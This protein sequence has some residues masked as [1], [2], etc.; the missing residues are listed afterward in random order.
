MKTISILMIC[1]LVSTQAL[2]TVENLDEVFNRQSRY[3]GATWSYSLLQNN[4]NNYTWQPETLN[5]TDQV[6][7]DSSEVW[8]L[9]FTP[10][11][12]GSATQD[13]A[14]THWSA[15]G[16]RLLLHSDRG[17]DAFSY[18]TQGSLIWMLVNA[19]GSRLKP[20]KG[21]A[22]QKPTQDAYVCWSPIVPDLIYS[23]DSNDGQ[24]LSD[25]KIYKVTVSD[26]TIS[27]D[28]GYLAIPD[29]SSGQVT[30]LKKAISGDGRKIRVGYNGK[31][32]PATVYPAAS[33]DTAA[34]YTSM[35]N[36]DYF[37][38]DPKTGANQYHDQYLTGAVNGSYGVWSILMPASDTVSNGPFWRARLTGSGTGGAHLHSTNET[39]PYT[40]GWG[41]EIEPVNTVT[42]LHDQPSP[43]CQDGSVNTTSAYPSATVCMDPSNHGS[44][45]RWGHYLIGG[46]TNGGSSGNL[47]GV[48]FLDMA[49]HIMTVPYN[50][51][52]NRIQN[53]IHS[54]WE[55]WS[56]WSI[57]TGTTS[58][59]DPESGPTG[60]LKI[61]TQKYSDA[62]SE[63]SVVFQ[64]QG[65][66][67]SG[68][69][70]E[71][72]LGP[73][74]SP[75]GT[76][77]LFTSS[78]LGT[79]TSQLQ[80]YWAVAYYPYPPQIK[81]AAK[82]SSNVRLTW[83]FNQGT[84]C[85]SDS[86]VSSRSG[87][88]PNLSTPRTYATRGWPHETLDC[89]PS[90]REIDKFRIWVSTDNSTWTPAGTTLYNNCRA[91][92]TNEC[93]MWSESSWTYDY[94]QPISSTRYYAITSL[95][96]SGLESRTLSNVWKVITDGSGAVTSQ[97][98]QT[99]YSSTP[100]A[101]SSFYTTAP[102]AP[103]TFKSTHQ[104]AP[105][106]TAGQYTIEWTAPASA[107]LVRHYNIYALDGSNPTSVQQRRIASVPA[108]SDY[109]SSGNFSYIDW[110]GNTAG[111]TQ[112][113]VTSVDYQGNESTIL[114]S[115][116]STP[117][118]SL[119][120][121]AAGSYKTSQSITLPATTSYC[122]CYT[123]GCTCTPNTSW[124]TGVPVLQNTAYTN[125]FYVDSVTQQAS[126]LK[127][128][129][130]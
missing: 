16:N 120:S 88:T 93:G 47:Y 25:S 76:K 117:A 58:F 127:R 11:N 34:G 112:Y 3:A 114:T 18:A 12:I 103:Q 86:G 38:G 101:R 90:P 81:S 21:S 28:A 68:Y 102:S 53:H 111:S 70:A 65:L 49:S 128:K 13:I 100:G 5:Y 45:D 15:N 46:D 67:S 55:A 79:D 104:K 56:D 6:T 122:V 94:A 9:T 118:V 105:A 121:P 116:G 27:H 109:A 84:S 50:S 95:E 80:T 4:S 7:G 91:N 123:K 39:S 110:L 32:Y 113:G 62:N 40:S 71:T 31:F 97:T 35:L 37:W 74:Q 23:G 99:A 98:Q 42:D 63:K 20:A 85:S 59:G 30:H 106:T 108:T 64:H 83:D 78:F 36:L 82:V 33:W 57:N 52:P 2:A 1:L 51:S 69:T 107:S 14:T 96:Y 17:S 44:P 43:W 26:T 115:G 73:L 48:S 130:R 22:A 92:N 24:G 87:P 60:V 41:G 66:S 19:D 89:P 72:E 61:V 129:H 126:Y 75:D 77:A 54:D 29:P 8:R 125:L 119:A 10:H 124:S